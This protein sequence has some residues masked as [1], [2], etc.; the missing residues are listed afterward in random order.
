MNHPP[1]SNECVGIGLIIGFFL[2]MVGAFS[3]CT[4]KLEK[5]IAEE[6]KREAEK[7]ARIEANEKAYTEMIKTAYRINCPI[8]GKSMRWL[9]W[10]SNDEPVFDEKS[11]ALVFTP[12]GSNSVK[13]VYTLTCIVDKPVDVANQK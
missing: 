3:S 2:C 8:V 9:S 10:Y 12:V 5:S 7:R 1:E 13:K 4:S 6:N 11:G